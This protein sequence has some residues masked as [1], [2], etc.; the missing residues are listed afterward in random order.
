M[1]RPSPEDEMP[2]KDSKDRQ[3]KDPPRLNLFV[4]GSPPPGST[5]F[6]ADG[7]IEHT[8]DTS[9]A[10]H[11]WTVRKMTVKIEQ[12]PD[13][14]E[15]YFERGSA[16]FALGRFAE[17]IPDFSRL[18]ELVPQWADYHRLRG[19]SFFHTGDRS[20]ALRDLGRYRELAKPE[21]L[22]AEAVTILEDLERTPPE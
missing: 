13:N 14:G 7:T 2:K 21:R 17:A 5:V 6:R 8:P 12:E 1:S 22:D 20:Q 11:A 9:E 10:R 15:W 4:G 3:K 19:L 18:I 16:L